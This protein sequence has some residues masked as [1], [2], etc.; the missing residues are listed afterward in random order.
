MPELHRCLPKPRVRPPGP[1]SVLA[2][3]L[4]ELL[5]VIAIMVMLLAFTIPIIRSGTDMNKSAWEIAGIIEQARAYAMAQNTYVWV[6]FNEAQAVVPANQTNT[7][8]FVVASKDGTATFNTANLSQIGKTTIF[9]NLTIGDF[10]GATFNYGNRQR[11]SGDV[12]VTQLSGKSPVTMVLP[13]KLSTYTANKTF[14]INPEGSVKIPT[15]N[16][17]ADLTMVHWIELGLQ[18]MRGTTKGTGD[19]AAIQIAGLTGQTRVYRP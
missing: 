5:A 19:T 18:P 12:Q 7:A 4:I 10:S 3:T 11:N 1:Q 13:G 14:Q 9:Q 16:S 2:F 17:L 8:V 15:A 6:G